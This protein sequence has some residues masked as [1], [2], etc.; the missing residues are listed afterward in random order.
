MR[1]L[2]GAIGIVVIITIYTAQ[3][4]DHAATI[5]KGTVGAS[6]DMIRSLAAIL[7]ASDAYYFMT[8]LAIIA[9]VITLVIPSKNK[10][11]FEKQAS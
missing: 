6:A 8:I 11:N 9:L 4:T 10:R 2:A 7:G 1:Q 3:S 5:T